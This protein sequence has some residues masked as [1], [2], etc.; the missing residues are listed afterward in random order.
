MN[1]ISKII[2]LGKVSDIDASKYKA[3]VLFPDTGV[4]SD[5]LYV[6]QRPCEVTEETVSCHDNRYSH[7]HKN[8]VKS[9][10][11]KVNDVVLCVF[12]PVFNADGFIIGGIY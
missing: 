12:L 6:L 7:S 9:W 4:V 5:W 11:P 1:D 3:R 2:R 10:M 8:N